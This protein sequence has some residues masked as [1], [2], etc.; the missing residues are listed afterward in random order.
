MSNQV[1][2]APPYDD[3]DLQAYGPIA[4]HAFNVPE[5]DLT[6]YL[7][8]GG[9][10]NFRLIRHGGT[11]AGGLLL[12]HMGQFYGGRSVPLVGVA[13]VAV[14][15][16][17]RGERLATAL[18]HGVM[19]ELHES[20]AALS[21]LYSASQ[22]LY[23]AAGYE[24]AGVITKARLPISRL[25]AGKTTHAI[26]RLTDADDAAT[27]RLYAR[28]A[29]R[30]TGFLD[31]P[32]FIWTRTKRSRGDLRVLSYG[33][34][35]DGE[36]TGYLRLIHDT[37]HP[38]PPDYNLVVKDLIFCDAETGR[39]IL[40]F[41]AGHSTQAGE[42]QWMSGTT[43]PLP[44]LLF[45]QIATGRTGERWMLRIVHVPA[46]LTQRSYP[47]PLRGELHL[48]VR[49][50]VIA[51][52]NGRFVLH[53]QDAEATVEPGGDGRVTLD[54][55]ALASLYAG[56]RSAEQLAHTGEASGSATDLALASAIFAGPAAWLPDWF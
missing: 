15:A 1:I 38:Q 11:V 30:Y 7:E 8:L 29:P 12:I 37:A 2:I 41:I 49:D 18:M 32:D 35:R 3:A 14:D 44:P 5:P 31:R 28:I 50:E 53:V 55:R 23:R 24:H 33:F 22:P 54:V 46:A 40:A 9:R 17:R 47:A 36:L 45:E 52:N 19:N 25:R 34:E 43:D 10:E 4:G 6:Q 26:R 16:C 51:G 42:L 21:A 20:G 56:H 27:R 39:S 13:A 48:Q